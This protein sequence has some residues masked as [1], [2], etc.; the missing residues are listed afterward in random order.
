MLGPAADPSAPSVR[1][2]S[3]LCTSEMKPLV[4]TLRS[5][6]HSTN[7]LAYAVRKGWWSC[8]PFRCTS[9]SPKEKPYLFSLHSFFPSITHSPLRVRS[10]SLSLSVVRRKPSPHAREARSYRLGLAGWRASG[11]HT[12]P[13]AAKPNPCQPCFRHG[14]RDAEAFP[15]VG[16]CCLTNPPGAPCRRRRRRRRDRFPLGMSDLIGN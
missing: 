14:F 13:Q 6:A 2:G 15:A 8:L 1:M 3:G 7:I 11:N 16:L 9:R 12:R 5:L 10:L 4:R